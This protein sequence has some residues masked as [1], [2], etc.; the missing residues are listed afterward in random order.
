MFDIMGKHYD[1]IKEDVGLKEAFNNSDSEEEQTEAIFRKLRP[2]SKY[3]FS[4]I[5]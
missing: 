5:I 4:E 1:Q 3:K 2:Q